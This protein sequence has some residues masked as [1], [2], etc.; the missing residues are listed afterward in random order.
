MSN[1]YEREYKHYV[2]CIHMYILICF[3]FN[4]D[5]QFMSILLVHECIL[6]QMNRMEIQTFYIMAIEISRKIWTILYSF[7]ISK[8]E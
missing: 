2:L 3:L 1:E 6:S 7:W 8:A 4:C 5:V